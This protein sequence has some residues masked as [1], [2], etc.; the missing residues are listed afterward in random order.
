V[1]IVRFFYRNWYIYL[2]VMSISQF[3]K[4]FCQILSIIGRL[5]TG[6]GIFI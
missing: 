1:R 2:I 6:I 3:K 5:F 4:K